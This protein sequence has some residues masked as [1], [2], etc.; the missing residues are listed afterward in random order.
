LEENVAIGRISVADPRR[1]THD[2]SNHFALVLSSIFKL[3]D[4]SDQ[5]PPAQDQLENAGCRTP[6]Q[7]R[8]P[9]NIQQS[10]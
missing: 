3:I 6:L 9:S 8:T 10:I 4:S 5:H 1:V 2:T 7:R